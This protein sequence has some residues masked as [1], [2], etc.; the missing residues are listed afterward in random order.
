MELTS[1]WRG[2]LGHPRQTHFPREIISRRR[3]ITKRRM[4]Y[5]LQNLVD[6]GDLDVVVVRMR[7]IGR[8]V[9]EFPECG[10]N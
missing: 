5:E 9:K 8:E 10:K 4:L 3:E 2:R 6:A 7:R 1:I